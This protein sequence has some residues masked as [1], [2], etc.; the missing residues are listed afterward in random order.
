M[1]SEETKE[2]YKAIPRALFASLITIYL[3]DI[4]FSYAS[5][6]YTDINILLTSGIS[7]IEGSRAM[8]GSIGTAVM[9]TATIL[10]SFTTANS[11]L[12]ALPR[13]FYGLARQDQIPKVF[14]YIYPKYRVP[15]WGTA[16]CFLLIACLHRL[17][18]CP[19]RYRRYYEHVHQYCLRRLARLLYSGHGR[20][21]GV[22]KE[23]S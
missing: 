12:A 20:R 4:V 1:F 17:H 23:V 13:M 19:G 5:L 10:A 14:G 3:I 9:S 16:T 8:M 15:I 11:H 6:K 22:A 18:L 21:S 2:A 7:H